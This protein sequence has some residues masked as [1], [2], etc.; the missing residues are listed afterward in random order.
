MKVNGVR[1]TTIQR[2]QSR[3]YLQDFKISFLATKAW[4]TLYVCHE[5]NGQLLAV[6][7]TLTISLFTKEILCLGM[8]NC[9]LLLPC[10]PANARLYS[11]DLINEGIGGRLKE[12]REEM[13]W[14]E[15]VLC[16]TI[17]R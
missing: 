14:G 2:L 12:G 16:K 7:S 17:K 10:T 6:Y 9:L 5:D 8:K 15:D 1:K 13:E 4:A 11:K 3:H